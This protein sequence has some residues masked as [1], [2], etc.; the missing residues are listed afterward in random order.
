ME[1]K[2]QDFLLEMDPAGLQGYCN[3]SDSHISV[4]HFIF[5]PI[6]L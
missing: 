4:S 2:V 6:P 5:Y 3:N 1:E